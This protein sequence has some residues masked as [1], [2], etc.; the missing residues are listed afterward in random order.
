MGK[1]SRNSFVGVKRVSSRQVPPSKYKCDSLLKE[2]LAVLWSGSFRCVNTLLRRKDI[3]F[4]LREAVDAALQ[5]EKGFKVISKQFEVYHSTW[6]KVI[7]NWKTFKL[8]IFPE[9]NIPANLPQGQWS[10]KL[11]EKTSKQHAF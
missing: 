10:E 1:L 9:V 8:S 11:G 7:H 6:K 4:E 2:V 5:C 3:G